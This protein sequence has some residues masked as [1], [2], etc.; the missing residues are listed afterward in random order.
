MQSFKT[1]ATPS[2]PHSGLSGGLGGGALHVGSPVVGEFAGSH[3]LRIPYRIEA[4]QSLHEYS[5]FWNGLIVHI[6]QS[7]STITIFTT[8]A[9]NLPIWL[10]KLLW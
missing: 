7:V 3:G 8:I 5:L 4:G 1:P 9:G 6:L 10:A 2:P